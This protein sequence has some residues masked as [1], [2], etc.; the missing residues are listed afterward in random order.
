MPLV[1]SIS[2]ASIG[3]SDEHKWSFPL[4]PRPHGSREDR[5]RDGVEVLK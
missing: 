5:T 4:L 3:R 1:R 2:L